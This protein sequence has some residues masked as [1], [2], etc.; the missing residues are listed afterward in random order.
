MRTPIDSEKARGLA[1]ALDACEA[2]LVRIQ[3]VLWR[4]RQALQG[5]VGKPIGYQYDQP[6]E[7][8]PLLPHPRFGHEGGGGC[9][10][11]CKGR[12]WCY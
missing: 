12:T 11:T 5:I 3:S 10:R 1:L 7:R 9:S 6:N 2:D 8:G 4:T